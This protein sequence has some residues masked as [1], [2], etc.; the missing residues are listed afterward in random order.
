MTTPSTTTPDSL[1]LRPTAHFTA[2]ST[3]LNDPNGLLFHEGQYHLFFQN[4]PHGTTWGNISWG[5]ATSADLVT[6]EEHDIAIPA[7][8][9]EMAFSGSAVVDERNTAGFAGPGQCALVAV[10]TS[11]RP[12]RGDAPAS[13]TQSL[14][15]SL[16]DGAT[17]TRYAGNP[18]LDIGSAEF[19][20][21]KVFWHG[22]D[23]GHWVMVAVEAVKRQVVL[24]TSPD[25]ITWTYASHFGPAHAVGG[26]WE[27]PDLFA[28]RIGDSDETRWVLVVSMNPGGIA[29]GSGT[30]YFVGNFDGFTFTADRV[31]D[32]TDPEDYDWLD[33]GRDYYAAVSFNNVPDGRRLMIGWASN[34]DYANET[35]THPWRSAMSL[36]REVTLVRTAEGRLRLVQRPVLPL[37]QTG[38][39]DFALNVPC[40]SGDRNAVVLSSEAGD[41]LVITVDGEDR[42]ITCD[43]TQ[44]GATDFHA[45]YPSVDW[46]PIPVAFDT[47][48]DLRIIVDATIVEIYAGGGLITFT[49][50]VFPAAPLNSIRVESR[51]S[52]G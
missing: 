21:P 45:E 41:Q 33:Y 50:Q 5:H 20:D 11:A 24:Y 10:Y 31:T 46:A 29:G 19:R 6:W 2:A 1:S 4:N 17:W 22:G 13:Q 37:D 23:D 52:D 27:C 15:F 44:S 32:S 48:L 14:A 16:D 47:V 34:W 51:D 7:T 26:V 28:L 25:L 30:Q 18:V 8:D 36:V 3:W 38:V 49:E 12:P 9:D 39:T 43:R 42:S 35:P 40:G